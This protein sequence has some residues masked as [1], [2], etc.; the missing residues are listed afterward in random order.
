MK[1]FQLSE[2]DLKRRGKLGLE[3]L[4]NNHKWDKIISETNMFYK[5]LYKN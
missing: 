3:Y 5:D 1:L 4:E 2:K